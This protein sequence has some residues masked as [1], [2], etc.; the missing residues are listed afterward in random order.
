[1]KPG[2][3][4]PPRSDAGISKTLHG[5]LHQYPPKNFGALHCVAYLS[6][7]LVMRQAGTIV[8]RRAKLAVVF[9][10][11]YGYKYRYR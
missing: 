2:L 6:S 10:A 9:H 4:T 7:L 11:G 5:W 1:M 8:L 3:I